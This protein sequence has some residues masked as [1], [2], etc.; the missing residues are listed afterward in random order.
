[1]RELE[2]RK[3]TETIHLHIQ[4]LEN[5]RCCVH[6]AGVYYGQTRG[7]SAALL[8]EKDA[9]PRQ[10]RAERLEA[11]PIQQR[12]TGNR[13]DVPSPQAAR[14]L[15]QIGINN[16]ND[17]T[18]GERFHSSIR[19]INENEKLKY[20]KDNG[21]EAEKNR[22][23]HGYI[24]ILVM[25]DP[26]LVHLYNEASLS[27]YHYYILCSIQSGSLLRLHRPDDKGHLQTQ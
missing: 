8:R 20:A 25:A 16:K 2:L 10:L 19:T 17:Y 6:H 11:L 13:Q 27:Y 3:R 15:K 9:L 21:E 5:Q 7:L 12:L 24:Q 22:K 23:L 1:M 14:K 18:V 26:L 4:F